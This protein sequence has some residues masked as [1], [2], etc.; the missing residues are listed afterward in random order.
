MS[1]K[2]NSSDVSFCDQAGISER[3]HRRLNTNIVELANEGHGKHRV[4][5]EACDGAHWG[6]DGAKLYPDLIGGEVV[7]RGSYPY[8]AEGKLCC[9]FVFFFF[10]FSGVRGSN[11][12]GNNYTRGDVLIVFLQFSCHLLRGTIVNRTKYC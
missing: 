3:K 6:R 10:F 8:Q 12:A 4:S 2:N 5:R 7:A 1:C 9:S 11:P